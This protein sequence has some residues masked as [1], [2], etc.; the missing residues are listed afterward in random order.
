MHDICLTN[1]L[2]QAVIIDSALIA[3]RLIKFVLDSLELANIPVYVWVDSQIALYW[4]CSHKRLPQFVTHRV[5]E[6]KLLLHLHLG[7]I[8]LQVTMLQIF[9]PGASAFNSF[10]VDQW[11]NL[12]VQPT[13]VAKMGFSIVNISPPCSGSN[14]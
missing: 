5:T 11:S 4:V 1:G 13:T 3:A 9:S 6:I 14:H 7:N 8:V 2:C 10:S 12:A